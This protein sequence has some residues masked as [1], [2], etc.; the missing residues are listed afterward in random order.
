MQFG[1]TECHQAVT[2]QRNKMIIYIFTCDDKE[3]VT[4]MRISIVSE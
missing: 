2:C 1:I 4:K 3:H